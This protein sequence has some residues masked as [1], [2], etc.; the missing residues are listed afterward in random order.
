MFENSD[1]AGMTLRM[2]MHAYA[3]N[4][5]A[6]NNIYPTKYRGLTPGKDEIDDFNLDIEHP[7]ALEGQ[8]ASLAG[9]S[10]S[11]STTRVWFVEECQCI[12]SVSPSVIDDRR[13]PS[14]MREAGETDSPQ[15]VAARTPF[16][17]IA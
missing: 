10:S 17:R 9:Q 2:L 13:Q 8:F 16:R 12:S 6:E 15:G 11:L 14:R 1:E 7:L 5:N 4:G 3:S